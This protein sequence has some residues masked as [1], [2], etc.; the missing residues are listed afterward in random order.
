MTESAIVFR[1]LSLKRAG[2]LRSGPD[3]NGQSPER[4]VSDGEGVPCRHCLHMIEKGD[5][6]LILAER[7]FTTVQ[8]YA[9]VGPIF[10]HARDCMTYDDGSS[11]LP[12]VL[13]DSPSYLLRGYDEG[14]RI[15]YGTG[16]LVPGEEIVDRA[17]AILS[18]PQVCFVHVRSASNNCWQARIERR[19]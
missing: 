11:D 19:A 6:Y 15:V 3:A 9:E 16:G 4:A 10:L 13:R 14:E 18:D 5:D 17:A 2:A 12:P 7:P 8:P 1:G